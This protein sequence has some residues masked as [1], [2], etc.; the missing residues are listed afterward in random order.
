VW[1]GA[2]E[3]EENEPF[4]AAWGLLPSWLVERC[5]FD[6][7]VGRL[8]IYLDFPRGSMFSCPVCQAGNC[9]AFDT[10][11]L[12]RRHLNF[13]QHQAFLHGMPACLA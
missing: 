4:Q 12:I 5:T 10:Y 7:T 11:S 9:K 13:F 6:E 1:W 3:M 8:D 2:P